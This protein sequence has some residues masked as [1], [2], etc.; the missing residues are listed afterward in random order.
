MRGLPLWCLGVVLAAAVAGRAAPPHADDGYLPRF[1]EEREAAAL[2]FVKKHLPE[3]LP[4]LEELKKTN[5]TQY[6][7]KVRE[8]FH[9]TELLAD[10]DDPKRHELE[11]KIWKAENRA[12]ALVARLSTPKEEERKKAEATLMELARELVDL[13]IAVLELKAEQLDKELGETRD[14][15]AKMRDAVEKHAKDRY[16]QLIEKVNKPTK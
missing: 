2:F 10:I 5:A 4:L 7:R 1:T 6:Q 13:D 12:C 15:L 11:V 9:V 8:I 14:E 16:Q 3:M